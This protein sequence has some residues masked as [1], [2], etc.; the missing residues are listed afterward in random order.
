MVLYTSTFAPFYTVDRGDGSFDYDC[1]GVE[2]RPSGQSSFYQ[3]GS[4]SGYPY[5]KDEYNRKGV[6]ECRPYELYKMCTKGLLYTPACG[7]AVS[8]CGTV[9]YGATTMYSDSS[10][11]TTVGSAGQYPGTYLDGVSNFTVS[12]N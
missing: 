2:G 5:V 12:C 7:T 11:T 1:N 9:Q 4:Q 8:V 10:C 6:F 3:I